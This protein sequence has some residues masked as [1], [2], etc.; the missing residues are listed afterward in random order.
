MFVDS[1]ALASQLTGR[2]LAVVFFNKD[3]RNLLRGHAS[4]LTPFPYSIEYLLDPTLRYRPRVHELAASIIDPGRIVSDLNGVGKLT[5]ARAFDAVVIFETGYEDQLQDHLLEFDAPQIDSIDAL[6]TKCE[7]DFRNY[8]RLDPNAE[9]NARWSKYAVQ[10][11][12]EYFSQRGIDVINAYNAVVES[13]RVD[14]NHALVFLE[15]HAILPAIPSGFSEIPVRFILGEDWACGKTSYLV[16]RMQEGASGLAGDFWFRLVSH[17]AIPSFQMQD[18]FGIKGVI[19]NL[20]RRSHDRNPGKPV[21]V[22]YDGRLEEFVFGIPRDRTYL[23]KDMHQFFRDCRF[24]I[25]HKADSPRMRDL[26]RRFA[27]KYELEA[28]QIERVRPTGDGKI[29]HLGQ[30]D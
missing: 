11:L 23:V 12:T 21:F 16:D 14:P 29:E 5:K 10:Y 1:D 18:I 17:D 25:V 28:S 2:R 13:V 7:A 26:V 19:A 24:V 8:Q 20:I 15:R 4:G 9:F 22:K 30:L 27:R 6:D 3:A